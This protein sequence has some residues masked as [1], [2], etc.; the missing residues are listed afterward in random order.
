MSERILYRCPLWLFVAVAAY[1]LSF[2][3][4]AK[5]EEP[6][7]GPQL[8]ADGKYEECA[9]Y[10]EA[11]IAIPKA[12]VEHLDE[13]EY[14]L[15]RID[16]LNHDYDETV[17]RL[18][19][20]VSRMMARE[21]PDPVI[22]A[23]AHLWKGRAH[24]LRAQLGLGLIAPNIA[25]AQLH[26]RQALLLEPTS[27]GARQGLM[28]FYM[29]VP[30]ALGGDRELGK[31]YADEIMEMDEA[32]GHAA[33]GYLKYKNKEYRNAQDA[34]LKSIQMG[35][36]DAQV[37]V[38]LASVYADWGK[39]DQALEELNR[40]LELEPGYPPAEAGIEDIEEARAK[41]EAAAAQKAAEAAARPKGSLKALLL[42]TLADRET[43]STEPAAEESDTPAAPSAEVAP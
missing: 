30:R 34:Y 14:Y 39:P 24:G 25:Y 22:F 26:F 23:D 42:E 31:K 35:A 1:G 38:G 5:K 27:L 19:K 36:N 17:R 3:A 7:I 11:R 8:F 10:Y 33:D 20:V 12:P 32:S 41:A 6:N 43:E 37:H 18:T 21:N 4:C 15:A 29:E 40:A 28:I 16:Y 13:G 2:A 9:A